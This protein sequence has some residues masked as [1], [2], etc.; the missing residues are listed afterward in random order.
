[1]GLRVVRLLVVED[2]PAYRNLVQL[3]FRQHAGQTLW[4]I[5]IAKDGEEALGLLLAEESD[6]EPLP[7]IILLD[8]NLPKVSGDE[9]LMR[10]KEH[11]RLRKI[12]ILI[13]SSSDADADIHMA[14]GHYANG[15]ITK[16]GSLDALAALVER[17]EQF[18]IAAAQ[19]PQAVRS[20]A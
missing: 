6:R 14:Y 4:E 7:D 10:L 11:R 12:P 2:S 13:F 15:Y 17:I 9:V 8:W 3:A 16:P 19:I 5:V 18:W 20:T 1:M